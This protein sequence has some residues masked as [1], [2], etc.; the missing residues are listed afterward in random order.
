MAAGSKGAALASRAAVRA[1]IAAISASGRRLWA[2]KAS[3]RAWRAFQM[4]ASS[5][6]AAVNAKAASAASA[7]VRAQPW[8]IRTSHVAAQAAWDRAGYVRS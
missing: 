2:E 3:K 4:E 6:F 8:F 1:L 5:A 7:Q